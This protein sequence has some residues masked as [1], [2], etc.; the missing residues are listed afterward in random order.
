ML[1][2]ANTAAILKRAYMCITEY[3]GCD[4]RL[5]KFVFILMCVVIIISFVLNLMF[6]MQKRERDQLF[7]ELVFDGLHSAHSRLNTVISIIDGSDM[8]WD[9]GVD[10][11]FFQLDM[12]AIDFRRIDTLLRSYSSAFQMQFSEMFANFDFLADVIS[13][14]HEMAVDNEASIYGLKRDGGILERELL[15]L[16]RLR[17]DI[18]T[19]IDSL[20]VLSTFDRYDV[21]FIMARVSVREI[22]N[23]L[24]DFLLNWSIP[25]SDLPSSNP[26]TLLL[27]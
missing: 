7:T 17:D 11:A 22:S 1:E 19:A 27:H 16:I 21:R 2:Y 3:G 15:F 10:E 12:A 18:G 13:M 14:P 6:W 8:N 4:M 24:S 20:S 5:N 9:G 23:V 26:F 25:A